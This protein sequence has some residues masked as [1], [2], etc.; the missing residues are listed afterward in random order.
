MMTVQQVADIAGG[1]AAATAAAAIVTDAGI[2][3]AQD[4]ASAYGLSATTFPLL[5]SLH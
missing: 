1:V 4:I 3:V 2:V 5:H